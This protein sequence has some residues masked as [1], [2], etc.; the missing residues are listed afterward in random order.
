MVSGYCVCCPESSDTTLADMREIGPTYFLATPWVLDVL[1]SQME[2]RQEDAGAF[3]RALYRRGMG[4]AQRA[5]TR[6]MEGKS[7]SLGDRLTS[8][9]CEPLVYGPLR[10]MLGLSKVRV[11]YAA[12]DAVDADLVMFF[13]ALGVNLKQ[14]YGSTETGFFVAIQRNDEVKSNTVGPAVAGVELK[15]TPDREILVRSSGL[16]KEY[17]GDPAN[18]QKTKSADGWLH[19]GDLGYLGDD[20]HLRVIGRAAHV[21]KLKD[22]TPYSPKAIENK[23]KFIRYVRDAV[24]FGEGRDKVCALIDIDGVAVGRWADKRAIS[25]TGHADLAS[26]E[27]VYGLIADAISRVNASL[28]RDP[29]LA[30]SQIS[31]FLIL[32]KELNADDGM[33]T[34]TGKLRRAAAAEHFRPL[35]DAMYDSRASVRSAEGEEIKIRDAKTSIPTAPSKAA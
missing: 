28:A 30:K 4:A 7:A 29:A 31:R 24:V 32:Q 2:L 8:A 34:R 9:L 33:L 27:E 3:S 16:F 11:A 23:L 26:R 20:G 22:G 12:G 35:V 19:T 25:Y 1:L 21:G 15:F 10:D 17:H 18:T 5:T 14:L 13:R 6:R